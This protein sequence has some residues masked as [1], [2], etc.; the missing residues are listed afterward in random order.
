MLRRIEDEKNQVDLEIEVLTM[1]KQRRKND[2]I[3]NI[4]DDFS[5]RGH[6][7]MTCDLMGKNLYEVLKDNNYKGLNMDLIKKF[8]I[9]ILMAINDLQD[10]NVIHAD[11]KP[12]NILL[13]AD[14][15]TRVKLI[16]F[17]SSCYEGQTIY[18]YI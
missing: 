12:E 16:D 5:F 8:T 17:G 13:T 7:C 11:L 10:E 4:I 6:T 3:A 18:T 15:S 14:S 9:N 2:H 1:M